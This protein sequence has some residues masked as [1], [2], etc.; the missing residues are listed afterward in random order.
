M[1]ELHTVATTIIMRIYS[2]VTDLHSSV[3]ILFMGTRSN[4]SSIVALVKEFNNA[5][6]E[7][8]DV[9]V[10]FFLERGVLSI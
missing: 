10:L 6:K 7:D 4:K 9:N 8:S 5:T 3:K 1:Y 2:M